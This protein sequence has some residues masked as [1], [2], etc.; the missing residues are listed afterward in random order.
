MLNPQDYYQRRVA[1][2]FNDGQ[3]L[4]GKVDMYTS[5]LDDPDGRASLS[6]EKESDSGYLIDA[7]IDE[8]KDIQIID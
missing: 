3:A 2:T 4:R 7:Y 8:I 5:D 1:I 6:I